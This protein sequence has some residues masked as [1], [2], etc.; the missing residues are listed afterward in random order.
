[1]EN[2]KSIEGIRRLVAS[3]SLSSSQH[4]GYTVS[5]EKFVTPTLQ[6]TRLQDQLVKQILL[7]FK[8]LWEEFLLFRPFLL[9]LVSEWSWAI[10]KRQLS[11]VSLQLFSQSQLLLSSHPFY[12]N[13]GSTSLCQIFMVLL[14]IQLY[15]P[16][17]RSVFGF[18]VQEE[19]RY[20]WIGL[21]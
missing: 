16:K 2:P 19:K 20:I 14:Q 18:I 7:M 13:S 15:H 10:L 3:C 11:L 12:K 6:T 21:I 1:M 17:W 5:L 4:I 8:L 9:L